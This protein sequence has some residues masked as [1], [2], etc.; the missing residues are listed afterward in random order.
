MAVDFS[1]TPDEPGA[2]AALDYERQA[3]ARR[4]RLREAAEAVVAE[5][6]D[7]EPVADTPDDSVQEPVGAQDAT[8]V[9]AGNAGER[10]ERSQPR[11]DDLATMDFEERSARLREGL[12]RSARL[13]RAA[14]SKD[15]HR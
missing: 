13:G 4:T 15:W 1:A 7:V 5:P 2:A 14:P 9:Q 10:R 3:A 11:I 12:D 8:E 6:G